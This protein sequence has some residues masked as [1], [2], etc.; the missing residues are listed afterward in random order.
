MQS[1]GVLDLQVQ[2][3]IWPEQGGNRAV[4]APKERDGVANTGSSTYILGAVG[5][6]KDKL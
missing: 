5:T 6:I 4:V 1:R 2:K 3:V